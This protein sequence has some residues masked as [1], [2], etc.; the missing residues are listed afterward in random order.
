MIEK[1]L[2]KPIKNQKPNN[3]LNQNPSNPNNHFWE[4]QK[5]T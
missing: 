1:F 2:S 3:F 4:N 5:K